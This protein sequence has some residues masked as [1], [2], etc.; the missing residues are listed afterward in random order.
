MDGVR[1]GVCFDFDFALDMGLRSIPRHRGIGHRSGRT[2]LCDEIMGK[3]FDIFAQAMAGVGL[4]A[5]FALEMVL[6]QNL[7]QLRRHGGGN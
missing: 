6:D 7:P 4:D 3:V 2:V 1:W 5:F